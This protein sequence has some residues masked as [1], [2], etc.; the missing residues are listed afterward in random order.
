MSQITLSVS[1]IL[2]GSEYALTIFSVKEINSIVLFEKNGKPYLTCVGSEKQ[3]Q[4]SRRKS[5]ANY[6]YES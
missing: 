4:P 6:I 3:R 1:S 2:K 5:F